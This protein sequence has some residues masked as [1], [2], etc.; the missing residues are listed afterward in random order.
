MAQFLISQ[1]KYLELLEQQNINQALT[2]LRE[3][4]APL[5]T[6]LD[7]LQSLSGYA[8]V[9]YH[10]AQHLMNR[11]CASRLI[12]CS[13]A[14]D[15]RH[16]AKWDGAAGQS[17]RLLLTSLQ[18]MCT[19]H[20]SSRVLIRVLLELVPPATLLPDRRFV[21]LLEEAFT[22]QRT[23]CLYHNA[24]YTPE[25]FSLFTEHHCDRA[26]SFPMLTTNILS[27]HDDE[28]WNIQWSHNGTFLASA[29]KDK[30]VRIWRFQVSAVANVVSPVV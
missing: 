12:M 20:C 29:S 14:E 21:T 1:Q 27:G 26:A 24:P 28:V 5:K 19:H 23:S 7:K 18:R 2:V 17:R 9:S 4:L 3:D 6:D 15:L 25:S 30:S 8:Q 22:H 10:C 16:R 13:S 11:M